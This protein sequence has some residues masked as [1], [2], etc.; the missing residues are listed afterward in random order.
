M[1]GSTEETEVATELLVYDAKATAVQVVI[2]AR[3]HGAPLSDPQ[4]R[5]AID[6]ASPEAEIPRADVDRIAALVMED[7]G[8]RIVLGVPPVLLAEWKRLSGGYALA[9]GTAVPAESPS[10]RLYA[11]TLAGL[12]AALDTGR[13]ELTGLGYADP[14]LS[15][16]V[17][18]SLAK[19]IGPQ[20]E[21][22]ISAMFASVEATPSDRDRPR[23]RLR[24]AEVAE[25]TRRAWGRL[26]GRQRVMRSTGA[27]P[28]RP[29]ACIRSRRNDSA[30]S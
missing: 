8:A 3:V 24:A 22:G 14:D 25:R 20:Y 7:P 26:R 18:E 19:D 4:G 30:P 9:D 6:P 12:R 27:R 11:D 28:S 21:A 29:A 2:V 5:L 23:W 15:A 17:R 13:L 16:L 10:A 1:E